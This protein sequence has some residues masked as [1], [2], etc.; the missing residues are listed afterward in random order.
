MK[1]TR[2]FVIGALV[3][4]V[5]CMAVVFASPYFMLY[6]LKTAHEQGKYDKVVQFLAVDEIKS[7]VKV[8]LHA[9]LEERLADSRVATLAGFLP[10]A[11]DTLKQTAKKQLDK[12]IDDAF[13][14][15]NLMQ[16]SGAYVTPES[17]RFFAAWAMVS[18]YV[19][20]DKFLKDLVLSGG[21][22]KKAAAAQEAIVHKKVIEKFGKPV[23]TKPVLSYCGL[24]CFSVEGS[25]SGQPVAAY[26]RREG[27]VHWRV[28]RV[29]L[30]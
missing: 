29:V 5:V 4:A 12:T 25:I 10:D 24:N 20:Y 22:I 11:A 8:D 2:F 21:D 14:K 9:R 15:D 28:S 23:P 27:L 30:P 6:Q 19:D 13:T 1:R 7:S 16:L 17:E 3:L 26:L 18:G